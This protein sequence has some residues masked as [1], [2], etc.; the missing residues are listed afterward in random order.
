[1]GLFSFDVFESFDQSP[2]SMSACLLKGDRYIDRWLLATG[3]SSIPVVVWDLVHL[4]CYFSPTAAAAA[5][6]AVRLLMSMPMRPCHVLKEARCKKATEV[7]YLS[8]IFST[9]LLHIHIVCISSAAASTG[10]RTLF[11]SLD[12]SDPTGGLGRNSL[13]LTRVH[14]HSLCRFSL[15]R[16]LIPLN[17]C[18]PR[19]PIP[20]HPGLHP[21]STL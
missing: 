9:C 3:S 18:P 1:M 11:T 13:S 20:S 5:V 14:S 21:A 17:M 2:L 8:R 10:W 7:P 19:P 4:R 15:Q 12:G 16:I 6:T